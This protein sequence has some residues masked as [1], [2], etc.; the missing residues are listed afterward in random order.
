MVNVKF[1]EAAL[2][3]L[4]NS[5]I[6][7]PGTVG[8]YMRKIGLEILAGA[9]V[10]AGMR[11]GDLRRKLYMRHSRG[12]SGRFQYVEVGSTSS[13]AY[14]HHEGTKAHTIT[15]KY[16]RVL[17]YQVGGKMVFARKVMHKGTRPNRYLST[18]MRKAVR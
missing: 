1:D 3:R 8:A 16:G 5:P 2:D 10:M 18:P 6:P 14:V 15:P 13:H 12:G 11:T 4:L 9:K 7:R 17:R